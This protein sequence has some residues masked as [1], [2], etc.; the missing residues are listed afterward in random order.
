MGL[1]SALQQY[2]HAGAGLYLA[3]WDE[4]SQGTARP[5]DEGEQNKQ[6]WRVIRDIWTPSGLQLDCSAHGVL[7]SSPGQFF[8]N[9][10]AQ[11]AKNT[12]FSPAVILAKNRPGDE[13]NG[14]HGMLY[15]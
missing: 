9:I 13:A 5:S 4:T 11:R 7:A 12:Y 15:L 1:M 2:Q 14:V 8:T 3:I 10:M 6:E